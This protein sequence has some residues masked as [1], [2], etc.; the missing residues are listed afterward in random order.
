MNVNVRCI[1]PMLIAAAFV[2]TSCEE[3]PTPKFRISFNRG[4]LKCS[5]RTIIIAPP[6]KEGT[7]SLCSS[8]KLKWWCVRCAMERVFLNLCQAM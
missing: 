8:P 7:I 4:N 1:L 2:I 6:N 5:M 3:K